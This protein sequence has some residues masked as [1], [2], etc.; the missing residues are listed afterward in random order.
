[1]RWPEH[2]ILI[3]L[4]SWSTMACT[5][6]VPSSRCNTDRDCGGAFSPTQI[7]ETFE[8][9]GLC[10]DG[11]RALLVGFSDGCTEDYV[12][13]LRPES[14]DPRVGRCVFSEGPRAAGGP[15]ESTDQCGS[16]LVCVAGRGCMSYCQ[17]SCPGR[18]SCVMGGGL[19]D[20]VGACL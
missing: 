1:M 3:C 4:L 17:G 16:G 12:C 20:G 15:C 10:V 2:S 14:A 6:T 18:I 13:R 11:C 8:G 9:T 5:A 7:C 19:P